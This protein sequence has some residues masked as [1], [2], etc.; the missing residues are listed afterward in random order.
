MLERR[1]EYQADYAM[2]A[3]QSF[4]HWATGGQ[5][6][7]AA[8]CAEDVVQAGLNMLYVL[9]REGVAP[10]NPEELRR[11]LLQAAEWLAPVRVVRELDRGD[12]T[13]TRVEDN[14]DGTE[15]V[16]S[17]TRDGRELE[18]YKRPGPE[19]RDG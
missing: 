9:Q 7:L 4:Q 18:R 16:V 11:K 5:K 8:G 14:G 12:G 6:T 2:A 17:L 15:D 10:L 1:D 19:Q 13:R 3:A